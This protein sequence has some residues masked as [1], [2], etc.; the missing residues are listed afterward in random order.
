[1]V[2]LT[3][4]GENVWDMR[5]S[6]GALPEHRYPT[7]AGHVAAVLRRMIV[8]GQVADGDFLPRQEDLVAQ[9]GVSHPPLREALR[10]LEAEGLVTVRRGKQ[11]GAVVHS[12]NDA[13][14]AY[15]T[16]LVLERGQTEL[17]DVVEALARVEPECAALCAESPDRAER[18][19]PTLERLNDEARGLLD[20]PVAFIE[21]T[22]LFHDAL[23]ELSPIQ[24]LKSLV[25]ALGALWRS[26]ISRIRSTAGPSHASRSERER[27]LRAHEAIV[28]SIVEGDADRVRKIM[29]THVSEANKH[30]VSIITGSTV[31]VTS[32]GLESVREATGSNGEN[33]FV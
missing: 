1:M 17:Q 31:D 13:G 18:I 30:W 28:R 32:G 20:D 26:Q 9:F 7:A 15:T 21:S 4:P 27:G 33:P 10:M 3:E 19:V 6:L 22:R 14:I 5:D 8:S 25:G 16:G 11:G 2:S 12:P 24:T 29:L 23:I